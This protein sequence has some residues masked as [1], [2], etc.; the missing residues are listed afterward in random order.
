MQICRTC[1]IPM[2][3]TMSFS[4]N[5]DDR[6]NE[7]FLKCPKCHSETKHQKLSDRDFDQMFNSELRK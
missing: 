4:K 6:Q 1:Y 7:K 2:E 3:F 5:K